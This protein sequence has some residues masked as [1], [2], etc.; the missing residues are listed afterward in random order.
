VG[1]RDHGGGRGGQGGRL[2]QGVEKYDRIL[3]ADPF[4]GK[5]AEFVAGYLELGRSQA[6]AKDWAKAAVNFNKA[7]SI[8]PKGPKAQEAEGEL[9]T[10]RAMLAK[11]EG[12]SA[13]EDIAR[14]NKAGGG[15]TFKSALAQHLK[16][17]RGWMLY[18]G[19][20]T[21]ALALALFALILLRRRGVE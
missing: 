3:L 4:Y 12:R 18:A 16:S 5:R 15:E 20:G 19:V 1:R 14:A 13:D 2:G 6:K 10:A 7:L 8:D 21:G 11:A 9:Y 17:K